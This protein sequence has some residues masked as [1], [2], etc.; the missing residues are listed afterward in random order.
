MRRYCFVSVALVALA[1][2][3]Y[4]ACGSSDSSSG[5][6]PATGGTAGSAGNGAAAGSPGTGGT[7]GSSTGGSAGASG[8]GGVAG[9]AGQAGAGGTSQD[10]GELDA[11]VETGEDAP[12]EGGSGACTNP[13]DATIMAASDFQS[14][15][16][17]CAT[18]NWGADPATKNCVIKDTGLSDACAT[19]FGAEIK[20]AA[21]KCMTQCISDSNSQQCKDCRAQNCDPAFTTCSGTPAN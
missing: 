12:V 14:K 21:T 20:C 10:G 4:V 3:G 16:S 17:D 19:C 15:V 6:A 1:S 8:T 9:Q 18:K 2:M 11:P 7:G 5:G 13:A